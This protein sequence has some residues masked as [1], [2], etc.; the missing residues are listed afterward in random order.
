MASR[1][2][3]FNRSA[4]FSQRGGY[5]TFRDVPTPTPGSLE[6]MYRRPAASAVDMGRMTV[7]DAVMKT[8]I[9]FVV[10]VGFAAL[11]WFVPA[12][13]FVGMIVGLVLGLVVSF[14]QSTN[15]ALV[16]GYAAAEGLFVGGISSVFQDR[17]PGIVS[18]AV[19]GT[20]VAFGA[21]LALYA[22]GVVKATPKFVKVVA[23][24][25]LAYMGIALASL[26]GALFGVGGG[27]GF[28]GVS[29]LGLLLCAAGVA[30]AAAYLVLDFDFVEQGVR[31]GLPERYSWLA[32]FG[33]L[34]T[35]VWLYVEL[36]RLLA[37]LRGND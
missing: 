27:W 10:L 2:P 11:G 6:D 5:A 15:P 32:A 25:G 8:L 12:L 33:L 24:A 29:G 17:W 4:A 36:L 28:Y 37:I 19:I 30:L 35:V 26:V 16:L 14:K 1:N 20:L 3:V 13:A 23:T 22:T 7:D 34:A 18:Q 9:S 21:M 31:N